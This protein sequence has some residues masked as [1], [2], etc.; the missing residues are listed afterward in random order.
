MVDVL[1]FGGGAKKDTSVRQCSIQAGGRGTDI[2]KHES[3]QL[4]VRLIGLGGVYDEGAGEIIGG[5]PWQPLSLTT[6]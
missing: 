1:V 5:R 2:I 6:K 3:T 4:P